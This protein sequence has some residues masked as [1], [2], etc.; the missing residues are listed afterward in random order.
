MKSLFQVYTSFIFLIALCSCRKFIEVSPPKTSLTGASVF[1]SNQT[2]A[3]AVTGLLESLRLNPP[4]GGGNGGMSVLFGLSSDEIGLYGSQDAMINQTYK[5]A[6]IS[7]NP[8]VFWNQMYNYIYQANATINALDA[9]TKVSMSLKNQLIGESKLV[10]A[11]SNFYLVNI[12][13]D[14]P[15][16]TRTDYLSNKLVA[17]SPQQEVY[18]QIILDLKDAQMLLTDGYAGPDGSPVT[19]RV[20]PNSAAAT[21]LL[22]RTY[23]YLQKWDS[24]EIEATKV[25]ND[26]KYHLNSD[27]NSVFLKNSNETIWNLEIPNTGYN[28]NDALSFLLA[29]FYNGGQPSVTYPFVVSDDLV[30]D[31]EPGD[32]RKLNW[33]ISATVASIT[34]Y[35][36][37][38]YKLFYTGGAPEEY[39][40]LLR[41]AE[42]YLIRAEARAKLNDLFGASSDLNV[43]RNRAGLGSAT[44]TSQGELLSAIYKER[45]VELFTEYGH[46][47]FDLKRTGRIDAVMGNITPKKGGTW[48]STDQLYPIPLPEIQ[49]D[50]NL[51]QNPGYN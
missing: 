17:R 47:W 8:A 7:N 46:R 30:N 43:I 18:Q 50:P 38:K 27:L 37:Y 29:Y 4:F 49:A 51:V 6:L 15:I 36:P 21:A 26:T 5:N 32:L 16:V 10:R 44:Q 1:E 42:Q 12:Y 22:A 40:A 23:L 13:G 24:A 14:V 28:T 2:A 20:R 19:E 11:I 41:L 9:S 31:F 34:Y 45:R 25:I 35:F 3:A 33:I 48:E 39:P